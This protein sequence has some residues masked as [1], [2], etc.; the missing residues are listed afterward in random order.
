M[1]HS[2]GKW[3]NDTLVLDTVGFNDK[4]WLTPDGLPDSE[5]IHMIERYRRPDLG[6]LEIDLTLDD[7]GAFAKPIKRHMTWELAPSEDVLESICTENN[8]YLEN[9]GLK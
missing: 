9:A 6:H 1:G 7:P 3:E 8:K 5:M 2:I 4:S